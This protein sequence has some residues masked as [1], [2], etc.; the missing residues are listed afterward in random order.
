MTF[1][2]A[3]N[4]IVYPFVIVPS[5]YLNGQDVEYLNR[6]LLKEQGVTH[7]QLLAVP[8]ERHWAI[9]LPLGSLS[10]TF[11]DATAAEEEAAFQKAYSGL[12]GRNKRLKDTL[13]RRHLMF[14]HQGQRFFRREGIEFLAFE[15]R[16]PVLFH[17]LCAFLRFVEKREPAKDKNG[18]PEKGREG[19]IKYT[20][21]QKGLI[22]PPRKGR[23]SIPVAQRARRVDGRVARGPAWHMY[24]DSIL[25]RYFGRQADGS[26]FKLTEEWWKR[27]LDEDLKGMRT[28]VSVKARMCELNRQL[29]KNLMV[30][31]LLPRSMIGKYQMECLGERVRLPLL[32]V[33]LDGTYGGLPYN[34]AL[35]ALRP[36]KRDPSPPGPKRPPGRPRKNPPVP[37]T[38]ALQAEPP[39]NIAELALLVEAASLD[40]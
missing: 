29:K 13:V 14:M 23:P 9:T 21:P 35:H 19:R 12:L 22:V 11:T 17:A 15:S 27:L 2:G 37:V 25:R 20:Y 10:G 31:G 32:R 1:S 4:V 16:H 6:I 7:F 36:I 28:R 30:D 38:P 39:R 26:R 5:S 8:R 24:E 40:W 3:R 33:R 34:E 18:L